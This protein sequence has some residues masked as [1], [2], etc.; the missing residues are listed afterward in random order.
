MTVTFIVFPV[1]FVEIVRCIRHLALAP[2]HAFLPVTLINATILV[3][4]FTVTVT[5]SVDPLALILNTFFLVDV[6]TLAMAQAIHNLTLVGAAITPVV[7]ALASDFILTELTL[8]NSS[9]GPFKSAL[10][11]EQTVT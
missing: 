6:G 2:F 5:H 4:E 1:A 11:V 8:V 9:V 10:A 3:S 7:G